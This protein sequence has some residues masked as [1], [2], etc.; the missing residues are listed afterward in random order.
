MNATPPPSLSDFT[1]PLPATLVANLA[2]LNIHT[3][4]DL[5][6]A[7]SAELIGKLPAGSVTFTE[8]THHIANVT[9]AFAGPA[10]TADKLI[11]ELEPRTSLEPVRSSGLPALDELIGIGDDFGI[12]PG[13]RLIEISGMSGSGKTALALH[14]TLHH[15][16]SHPATAALWLD[17]TGD[18]TPTRLA[19]LV[20]RSSGQPPTSQQLLTRLNIATAFDTATAALTIK[21]LDARNGRGPQRAPLFRFVVIDT[22]TALFG[23]RLSNLSSQGTFS[24][25]SYQGHAEMTSFMRL[26]R[27]TAQKLGLCVLVLNDATAAGH[28]ALG[29]SFTFLIDATVWLTHLPRQDHELRTAQVLR[30]R[31]SV[32]VHLNPQAQ[33]SRV[34]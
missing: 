19:S 30:S 7:S 14:I 25:G 3:A 18:L 9:A 6:F 33:K 34:Y 21:A 4:P 10:I 26:L 2:S 1:P 28:P 20:S 13:A 11:A 16:T 27:A 31:V 8:L 15:L 23:P 5:I 32:R 17:T 24:A 22:V 12:A 29:A